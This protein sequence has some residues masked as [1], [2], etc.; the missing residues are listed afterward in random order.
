[1]GLTKREREVLRHISLPTE[2]IAERLLISART[3]TAYLVNLRTKLKAKNSRMALV[4]ALKN[5]LV[6]VDELITE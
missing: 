5:K 6:T 1:M 2:T 3:V 4:N